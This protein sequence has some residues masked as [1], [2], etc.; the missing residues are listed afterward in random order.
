MHPECPI[1]HCLSLVFLFSLCVVFF[2]RC[3]CTIKQQ[4]CYPSTEH[5]ANFSRNVSTRNN[6][7]KQNF[8][9]EGNLC[10]SQTKT[11]GQQRQTCWLAGR[12][13]KAM[14]ALERLLGRKGNWADKRTKLQFHD[15]FDYCFY[16]I[17][18]RPRLRFWLET[19]IYANQIVRWECEGRDF[20]RVRPQDKTRVANINILIG[21]L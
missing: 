13:S 11:R 14:T 2:V 21:Y 12:I 19:C 10:K 17:D 3:I 5:I 9:C 16:T 15:E 6:Q 18:T 20:E 1:T 4:Q 8:Y 7:I